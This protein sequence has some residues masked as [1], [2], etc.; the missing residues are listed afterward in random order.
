[1]SR[2]RAATARGH[3]HLWVCS[4]KRC[5]M[6]FA[7]IHF[8]KA[9]QLSTNHGKWDGIKPL[10][11]R[12]R[13]SVLRVDCRYSGQ[14]VM[15]AHVE[16]QMRGMLVQRASSE[17]PRIDMDPPLPAKVLHTGDRGKAWGLF[18]DRYIRK[19]D[20]LGQYTGTAPPPPKPLTFRS[21]RVWSRHKECRPVTAG[22]GTRRIRF[23]RGE[24]LGVSSQYGERDE[25]EM[26]VL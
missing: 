11:S 19:G 21:G 2:E 16:K 20:Y 10:V 26:G 17:E 13:V 12:G 4:A 3:D 1:M 6:A 23:V 15:P 14:N 25:G 9:H 8:C 18:A 5:G 22:E 24:G 7:N